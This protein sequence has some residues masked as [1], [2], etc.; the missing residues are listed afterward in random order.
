MHQQKWLLTCLV[1]AVTVIATLLFTCPA[2]A[3][4]LEDAIAQTPKGAEK[5]MINPSDPPGFMEI[6]GAP[7]AFWLYG[8][9]WGV[10]VGWIFSSVGAFGGIMAGVGHISVFGLADYGDS[11]A[12]TSPPL[13]KLLTDSIR[14]CNQYLVGLSALIS[15]LTYYRMGR[16]V[17]A[18]RG[19]P[20]NRQRGGRIGNTVSH[21]RQDQPDAY[22]GYFGLVVFAVA[23]VLFYET[24]PMGQA[25][26]KASKEA[27]RAFEDAHIKKTDE[28]RDK[29]SEYARGVRVTKMGWTRIYF[30]FYGVEFS[31]TPCGLCWAAWA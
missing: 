4:K 9:L 20:G 17:P 14:V 22:Q 16:L 30:T 5:G 18:T 6:P 15:S 8:I 23:A 25:S 12:K 31:S 29:L 24:T 28:G 21:R 27:A 7:R 26:R 1:I 11:F 2:D 3:G 10:W 13:N 19:R